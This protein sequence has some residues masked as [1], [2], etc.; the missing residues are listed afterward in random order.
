MVPIPAVRHAHRPARAFPL[1]TPPST[2]TMLYLA[3]RDEAHWAAALHA[4]EQIMP[5]SL[6][7]AA[8]SRPHDAF[9]VIE[10]QTVRAATIALLDGS[11]PAVPPPGGEGCEGWRSA[12]DPPQLVTVAERSLLRVVDDDKRTGLSQAFV[13][14]MFSS[15]QPPSAGTPQPH[16]H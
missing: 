12:H 13:T 2:Q 6:S 15:M 16:R 10:F 3:C 4:V 11:P 14:D 8:P 7:L 9:R 1:P 5:L